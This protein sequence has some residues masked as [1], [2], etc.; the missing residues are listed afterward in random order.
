MSQ[1]RFGVRELCPAH[2]PREARG[3]GRGARGAGADSPLRDWS[4]GPGLP[5]RRQECPQPGRSYAG[6]GGH[7]N[8]GARRP[9]GRRRRRRRR[10]GARRGHPRPVDRAGRAARPGQRHQQPQ[11]QADPRWPALPGDARLRS[12]PRGPAG[13]RP[14]AHP[15]GP[16][17]G[18]AGAVP[19][20]ADPPRLGAARTSAPGSRSTTAWRWPASTTWACRGTST[21]PARAS[22]GSPRT[23]RPS[24]SP[25]RSAT[26]TA[27]STTPGW[28]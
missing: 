22:P 16:A 11:Q 19:L 10:G 4:R 25:A 27:R 13:A 6:P 20:P 18:Q 5:E 17:P 1:T 3:G 23:S 14:A 21:C 7:G 8:R 24:R 12:G 9:G 26:T 28:S 15:A 2:R